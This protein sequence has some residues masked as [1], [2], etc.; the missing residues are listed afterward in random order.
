M[1]SEVINTTKQIIILE[2]DPF[3]YCTFS[4]DSNS[5]EQCNHYLI[6]TDI[7]TENVWPKKFI[8]RLEILIEQVK[9]FKYPPHT[10]IIHS[11]AENAFSIK[12]EFPFPIKY[13]A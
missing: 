12:T 6:S 11:T 1:D 4:F 13:S 7:C 3:Y 10:Y 5:V 9:L 2:N 8:Q